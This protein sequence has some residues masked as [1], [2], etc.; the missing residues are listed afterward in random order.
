MQ[1]PWFILKKAGGE[2]YRLNENIFRLEQF[3]KSRIVR[4][5]EDVKSM[6][7]GYK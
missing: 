2:K 5:Y 4:N 1:V 6:L 3:L 7:R